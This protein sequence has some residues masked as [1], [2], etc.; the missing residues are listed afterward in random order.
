MTCVVGY[1][2]DFKSDHDLDG[3]CIDELTVSRI[4]HGTFSQVSYKL[5]YNS[6][7]ISD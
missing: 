1:T 2:A 4:D 3:E 7:R 6:P 5:S